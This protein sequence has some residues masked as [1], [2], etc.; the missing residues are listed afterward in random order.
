MCYGFANSTPYSHSRPIHMV[1]RIPFS[2]TPSLITQIWRRRNVD[3][4]AI[5][6][7]FL[8]RLRTRLTLGGLTLP[9]NPWVYGGRVFHPSNRYS[10]QHH[11]FLA[12]HVF[13]RSRFNPLGTLLYHSLCSKRNN[14]SAASVVCLSPDHFRCKNS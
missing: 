5:G 11:H 3:L 6:Y 13:F 12:V 9:R 1:S 14:K 2:V 8:P 7:A 10:F 4:L